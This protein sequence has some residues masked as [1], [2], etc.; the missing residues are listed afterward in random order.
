MVV[1]G[2]LYPRVSRR[3][4]GPWTQWRKPVPADLVDLYQRGLEHERGNRTDL[5]MA[6]FRKA[7]RMDPLNPNLRIKIAMLEE[8][9]DLHLDA[10]STYWSIVHE[11][12]RKLW[13]GSDRRVRLLALYRLAILLCDKRVAT[14]WVAAP[15]ATPG[16]DAHDE[17]LAKLRE[18]LLIALREDVS[19]KGSATYAPPKVTTDPAGQV[20]RGLLEHEDDSPQKRSS[21]LAPLEGKTGET[22]DQRRERVAEVLQVLGLKLIEDLD[23]WIRV[24]PRWPFEQWGKHRPPL[25]RAWRRAEFSHGAVAVSERLIRIR[26]AADR[27]DRLVADGKGDQTWKAEKAFRKL[28][29][30]LPYRRLHDPCPWRPR[31]RLRQWWSDQ[32]PD[33]WQLH[34]NAACAI[35]FR[36]SELTDREERDKCASCA[37]D[38]LE[39]YAHRAGSARVGDQRDWLAHED[40][41]LA[42]L[43]T[44]PQFQLWAAQHLTGEVLKDRLA[45]STEIKRYTATVVLRTARALAACWRDRASRR[46]VPDQV[47]VGWW[48]QEKELWELIATIS[49][50]RRSWRVRV[51]MMDEIDRWSRMNERFKVEFSYERGVDP[52]KTRSPDDLFKAIEAGVKHG[53]R[54]SSGNESLSLIDWVEQRVSDVSKRADGWMVRAPA[55]ALVVD[56][57]ERSAALRAAQ[58]WSRLADALEA[59]LKRGSEQSDDD[60]DDEWQRALEQLLDYVAPAGGRFRGSILGG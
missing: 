25:Q 27:R 51:A 18:Y 9:L 20:A 2:A 42:E 53:R 52:R 10:W 23:R 35:A 40:P 60:L 43:R 57:R 7:V 36:L 22:E 47:V 17:L 11:D 55:T 45:H 32:R 33:C 38:E 15:A 37:V 29:R 54:P 31:S 56:H 19:F 24:L 6:S 50:E 8:R 59:G 48:L 34:Y 28:S 5:A 44:T 41:D 30:R 26:I 58:I 1:A 4:K 39:R 16:P 49:R 46:L 3:Y 14:E 21:L 13:S 12:D